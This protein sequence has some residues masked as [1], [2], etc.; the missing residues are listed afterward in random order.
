MDAGARFLLRKDGGFCSE[1]LLPAGFDGGFLF[2]FVGEFEKDFVVAEF[3]GKEG[4][5]EGGQFRIRRGLSEDGEALAGAGFNESGDEE[6]VEDVA[7][8]AFAD[9][10]AER[11]RVGIFVDAD[12]TAAAADEKAGDL[13]EVGGFITGDAS[14]GFHPAGDPFTGPLGHEFHGVVGGFFFE[15]G[16]INEKSDRIGEN[17]VSPLKRGA[18]EEREG[19]DFI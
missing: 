3:G 1:Q 10:E 11:V 7:D 16:V 12:E 8:F 6:A 19:I 2:D 4:F 17:G 9:E 18:G 5:V 14:H 15:E 13:S